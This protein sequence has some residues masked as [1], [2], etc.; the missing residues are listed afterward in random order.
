[1]EKYQP[2]LAD[3]HDTE[4]QPRFL[5]RT[6]SIWATLSSLTIASLLCNFLA[7]STFVALWWTRKLTTNEIKCYLPTDVLWGR[8]SKDHN[9]YNQ[10]WDSLT[11]LYDSSLAIQSSGGRRDIQELRPIRWPLERGSELPPCTKSGWRSLGTMGRYLL[12]LVRSHLISSS[13]L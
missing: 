1:M 11:D 8:E 12:R 3:D 10:Y 9:Q 13:S 2:L 5:R 7:T 6:R 4:I